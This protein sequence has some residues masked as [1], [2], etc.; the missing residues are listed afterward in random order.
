MKNRAEVTQ[1]VSAWTGQLSRQEVVRRL[2]QAGVPAAPV[3]RAQ[4]ILE[5]EI[6][7]ERNALVPV[8]WG[9]QVVAAI[10]ASAMGFKSRTSCRLPQLGEHTDEVLSEL[11]K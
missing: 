2:V 3:N 7:T 1:L 10:P 11:S 6:L 9:D 4:D 8:Q 5:N